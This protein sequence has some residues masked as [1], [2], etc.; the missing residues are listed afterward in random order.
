MCYFDKK[1]RENLISIHV[2]REGHDGSRQLARR[3][4][5]AFQST[6]PARGTTGDIYARGYW[7]RFQSTC[8]ARGTTKFSQISAPI[9]AISIHVPREGHDDIGKRNAPAAAL[10]SIHV[11]REGHD[12]AGA[13][14][15]GARTAFQSTCPARGTTDIDGELVAVDAISI[16]VPR[17]GHDGSTSTPLGATSPFQSTCPARGTTAG[18]CVCCHDG[19]DFNPRAP[20]GARQTL[21]GPL[22]SRAPFQSTCPARGTTS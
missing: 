6:C 5:S 17:E 20:R 8:P 15:S 16:H 4:Q 22:P 10:I 14:G 21:R 2:P 19:R 11:P 7:A 3:K 13:A 1:C 18:K 9:L 12:G